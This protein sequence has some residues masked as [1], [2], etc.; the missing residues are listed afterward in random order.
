MAAG[1]K[2]LYEFGPFRVDPDQQTL[3]RDGHPI[4][5]TP[6]AFETLLILV[7]N[8]REIVSKDELMRLVWPDSFVEEGN[9]SQNIF[10]LRRALGDTPDSRRYIATLPGRGYRFTADVRSVAQNVDDVVVS[11]PLSELRLQTGP[12]ALKPPDHDASEA[13]PLIGLPANFNHPG[14]HR[15]RR[16]FFAQVFGLLIVLTGIWYGFQ[17]Y[18]DARQQRIRSEAEREY[19]LGIELWKQ[20]HS[21]TISK[22][23]EHYQNAIRIDRRFARAYSGLADAYLALPLYSS[24]SKDELFPKA[25]AAAQTAV[26]LDPSLAEAHISL[27]DAKAYSGDLPGAD[28]EYRRGL[29]L[30]QDYAT[31]HQWYANYLSL[32][33]RHEEAIQHIRKAQN[34][35]PLSLVM[36]H[37]AGQIYYNARRYDLAIAQFDKALQIDPTFYPA[38]IRL[39][40]SLRQQGNYRAALET[41]L[42]FYKHRGTSIRGI[43]TDQTNAEKLLL[44]FES[45]GEKEYWKTRL[46][47]QEESARDGLT[48][49]DGSPS[50]ALAIDYAQN[51]NN[52]EAIALLNQIIERRDWDMYHL[53]TEPDLDPLRSDPRFVRL[54]QQAG[55]R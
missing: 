47:L 45:G 20:R 30:N 33:G 35:E 38:C 42:E 12:Q 15:L 14:S 2:F 43:G 17:K 40:D 49:S 31:G 34:L 26:S 7:R 13:T 39:S 27:A 21:D 18:Q 6:K 51:G 52:D 29:E 44:A 25:I 24:I 46:A 1:P 9:L 41:E 11:R 16:R 5:I 48:N 53:N 22:A 36:S 23:I 28:P 50:Y 55:F 19:Q 4:P 8:S 32:L 10:V 54:L 3:S 37:N